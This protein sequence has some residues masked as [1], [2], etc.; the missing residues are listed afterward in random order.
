MF[1]LP[2]TG[3]PAARAGKKF[4]VWYGAFRKTVPALY[5]LRCTPFTA[6]AR[7]DIG[8][9]QE[10][11]DIITRPFP[12]PPLNVPFR[13]RHEENLKLFGCCSPVAPW[14]AGYS[15][16]GRKQR[17]RHLQVA[18]KLPSQRMRDV[19]QPHHTIGAHD[20]CEIRIAR[21]HAAAQPCRIG[22]AGEAPALFLARR[23][24]VGTDGSRLDDKLPSTLS[25]SRHQCGTTGRTS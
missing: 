16:A 22:G 11:V 17:P 15:R 20:R 12:L 5:T 13:V 23:C 19:H 18:E 6:S 24:R 3:R 2:G 10:A 25:N 7:D 8:T 9:E 1:E 21:K 14:A 4:A